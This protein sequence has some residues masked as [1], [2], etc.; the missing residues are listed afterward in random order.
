M[1]A[2]MCSFD[3]GKVI[4]A[5]KDL[6]L[7]GAAVVTARAAL[8]GISKWRAE[9]QGK[10]DFDLARRA[11]GAIFRFQTSFQRA[12]SAFTD[13]SE[14]PEGYLS[15]ETDATSNGAA[16]AKVFE[17]RLAKVYTNLTELDGI[18][19]EMDALWGEGARSNVDL[20]FGC[21][22]TLRASMH[23]YVQDQYQGGR[24]FARNPG[25]REKVES[26]VWDMPKLVEGT[27]DQFAPNELT[28]RLKEAVKDSS[29]ELRTHLPM[30]KK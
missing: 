24:I 5:V 3:W 18:T 8:K 26:H 20:L 15:S 12:R 2:W 9:E 25:E 13:A 22:S 19:Q 1:E 16:W 7:A 29:K 10:A 14:F 23:M 17:A 27:T 11:L 30:H 21:Y 6:V 28:E 4:G